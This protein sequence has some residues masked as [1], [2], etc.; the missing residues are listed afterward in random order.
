[1]QIKVGQRLRSVGSPVE[2]IVISAA[3]GEADLTCGGLP[4]VGSGTDVTGTGTGTGS[5]ADG[6]W[7][8]QLGKRYVSERGDLE[9]LCVKG[10]AG[11]LAM[12]GVPLS[13]KESKPLPASD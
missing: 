13:L 2:V 6:G 4:M 7:S 1:V 12:D 8:A 10:G 11:E 9:L 5:A 3:A